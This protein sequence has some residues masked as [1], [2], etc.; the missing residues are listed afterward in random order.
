M[1]L[2]GLCS[3]A[4]RPIDYY[5]GRLGMHASR[6]TLAP[7]LPRPAGECMHVFSFGAVELGELLYVFSEKT[8]KEGG[9]GGWSACMHK[10]QN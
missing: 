7:Y 8:L 3:T 1:R 2:P 9:S 4:A 10:K 6:L 5:A